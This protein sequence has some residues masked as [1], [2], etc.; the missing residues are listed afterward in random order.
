MRN[1]NKYIRNDSDKTVKLPTESISEKVTTTS[2]GNKS[3]G[4]LKPPPMKQVR[5]D[6][7]K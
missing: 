4:D 6:S 5:N 7:D 3:S 1:R 2:S